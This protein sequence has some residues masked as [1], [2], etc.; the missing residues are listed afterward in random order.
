MSVRSP[1]PTSIAPNRTLLVAFASGHRQL[2]DFVASTFQRAMLREVRFS[3]VVFHH[4]KQTKWNSWKRRLFNSAAAAKGEYNEEGEDDTSMNLNRTKVDTPG[5][6]KKPNPLLVTT[7]GQSCTSY[8][9]IICVF[10]RSSSFL[11]SLTERVDYSLRVYENCPK[12]PLVRMSPA[13][14][15]PSRAMQKQADSR[16]HMIVQVGSVHSLPRIDSRFLQG[17][18]IHVAIQEI[19]YSGPR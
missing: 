14:A 10:M 19:P 18:C 12:D 17:L 16:H 13:I 7:Y 8:Q 4:P 2:D 9:S 3:G 6:P 11:H 15:S 5:Y 1:L